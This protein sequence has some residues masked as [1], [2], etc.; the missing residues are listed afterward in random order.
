VTDTHVVWKDKTHIGKYS[1]PIL[2]NGLIY[3]AAEQSFLTCLDEQSG[4]PVWTERIGGRYAASPICADGRIYFFSQEGVTTVIKP[5]RSLQIL[6]TNILDDGFMA[7]PAVSDKAFF[8]RTKS[9][10]YRVESLER[11]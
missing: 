8:L 5:G 9:H 6:S 2:V 7:S 10:L 11:F 3:T 4:Q 1:S